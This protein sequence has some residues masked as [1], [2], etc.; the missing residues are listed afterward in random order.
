MLASSWSDIP[1][2][3]FFLGAAYALALPIG[4]ERERSGRGAGLRTFPIV[5]I[6]TCGLVIVARKVLGDASPQHSRILQG[7][8]EGVGF[9]GAGAILKTD[10]RATGTATAASIWNVAVIGA[11]VGYGLIDVG[12]VLSLVNFLTLRGLRPLKAEAQ[13]LTSRAAP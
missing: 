5:A 12:F 4:W 6:A 10:G 3:L 1:I 7:V 11:A 9:L 2:H 13:P 8:I